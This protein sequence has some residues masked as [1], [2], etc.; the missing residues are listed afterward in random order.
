MRV[1]ET[2]TLYLTRGSHTVGPDVAEEILRAL[3]DDRPTLTIPVESLVDD[4]AECVLTISTRHIVGLLVSRQ[5]AGTDGVVTP[6]RQ[7]RNG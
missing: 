5:I 1:G 2:Y 7:T 3:E 4:N 6:F